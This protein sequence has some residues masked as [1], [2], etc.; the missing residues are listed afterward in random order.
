MAM[1][2][3]KRI[4][5]AV[6]V[7]A[8]VLLSLNLAVFA[9]NNSSLQG[10]G[11]QEDPYLVSEAGQLKELEGKNGVYVKLTADI[12]LSQ[13]E[14][15]G[16]VDSWADYYINNFSGTIDGDGHRIYNAGANSTLIANFGGGEL[17]NFT[18]ELSGQ[19]AT[20]V[21]NAYT[22]GIEY[23]Y[24]DINI[25]G[26]INYTSNNNNENALV[27]YAGGNTTLTRVNV[28]ANIQSPTYNSIF[29]GYTPFA[30]SHYKLVDCTYSGNAVM[31]QWW[32]I[33][34]E[35][36]KAIMENTEW[37]MADNGYFRGGGY[38][39]RYETK[40]QMPA[41]MI[42]LNLVKGL[43]PVLQ[44]A[45][46]WTVALPEEV[47][48]KLWK[49]TDYTWPCTWFAP[50]CDGK[51]GPFKTAYDVMNNWGAN[52]GAISYGHIGAD[53]ITMCSM[54]RIPVSMHNVP[55]K[56]I[57]RPAAWNAFG[58][59]KE[60]ADFRACKNYGPLYK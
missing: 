39:S 25:S 33:T 37:C 42:R 1:K 22:A 60:G 8:M 18:F 23:N 41:T 12:D 43:G 55:E 29:I 34:E 58:M 27:V 17:K 54:L 47:S 28:S 56:D 50:R 24:T 31:K 44:I 59:D 19:P 46:G 5:C 57:Y 13:A 6:L 35:D 51:E 21:W 52:H 36:Q 10:T 48:D 16:K 7:L 20:L 49:R 32:D 26:S 30:N 4:S 9:A 53:L 45:E 40:A 15:G 11:T 38:S 14:S 2:L 3:T